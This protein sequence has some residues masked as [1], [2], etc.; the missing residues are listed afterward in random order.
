MLT[1][2]IAF[3]EPDYSLSIDSAECRFIDPVSR[4]VTSETHLYF[5]FTERPKRGKPARTVRCAFDLD[6][7][8]DEIRNVALLIPSYSDAVS[9]AVNGQML[10]A[11]ELHMMRN[12][13]VSTLP[14][15]VPSLD[16]ALVT[17][18][19]QFE[20]RVSA[21]PGHALALDRIFI[22]DPEELRAYYHAKWL[23]SAIIPT[24]VVG[25]QIALTF[26]FG[27]IWMARPRE[28]EF[29]WLA[30]TLALA[31]LRGTSIIPDFGIADIDRPFWNALV[32]WE[33]LAGFMFCR[34]LTHA[35]NGRWTSLLVLPPLLFTTAYVLGPVVQLVPALMTTAMGL[36]ILYLAGAVWTL[37][38]AALRADRDALIVLPGMIVLLVFVAH[39]MF[40]ILNTGTSRIFL[41]RAVYACFLLTVASLMTLR[42]VRAMEKLDNVA[43]ALNQRVAEVE[44]QLHGTYEE[45]RIRREAEAVERER[46][47]LMRDLHDGVGGDLA[48]MLALA[49]SE[50]PRPK[51]IASHA[52]AALTDM[53]LIIG[54]LED[55]GGDL[56]L[57]LGAWRERAGPQLRVAGLDLIWQVR[58][59]PP[60]C[61]MKPSHVLDVLRIVQEAV[62]NIIK[63]ARASRVW[64]T[65][66]NSDNGICLS[67]CDDGSRFDRVPGGNG[68]TNMRTRA[69]RLGA[70]FSVE[71]VDGRTCVTL[72]LPRVLPP[73]DSR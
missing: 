70:R 26:V 3:E 66:S 32:V 29:G 44:K 50:H 64:I 49:D 72:I 43:V 59:V 20:V 18:R 58:D 69:V 45:L 47:R 48:S 24:L 51:E 15:F 52:R 68:I 21:L 62:T 9:I 4:Q 19:N 56:P 61:G 14:A 40:V 13:R 17:G 5:P 11:S 55:Y 2:S 23:L 71:R 35:P 38:P 60:L 41:A 34:A 63:H 33:A 42:F 25:S 39:D 22:G 37:A 8:E 30:V 73:T 10:G 67:I 53:R 1:A 28:S 31:A 57:A 54:S 7:T 46:A 16:G 65:T 36:V 27:L 12:L 6:L